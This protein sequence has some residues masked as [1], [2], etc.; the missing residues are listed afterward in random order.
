MNLL[1]CSNET[2]D[3]D[4]GHRDN[5]HLL[6]VRIVPAYMPLARRV[7][8][9][10]VCQWVV[11][12][13]VNWFAGPRQGV[14]FEHLPSTRRA[15]KSVTLLEPPWSIES[16]VSRASTRPTWPTVYLGWCWCATVRLMFDLYK[17]FK[18]TRQN[19]LLVRIGIGTTEQNVSIRV[20]PVK[21]YV[22]GL[23]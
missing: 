9:P 6:G 5:R 10:S 22:T 4:N 23:K 21:V 15:A 16:S 18:R 1:D 12:R 20:S 19:N 7:Q 17:I 8:V 3:S 2:S 14:G 13:S 11:R